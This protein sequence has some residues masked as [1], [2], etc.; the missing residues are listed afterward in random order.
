MLL[1][2]TGPGKAP[3]SQGVVAALVL[4]D[5]NLLVGGGDGS[6][7]VMRTA[8]EPSPVNP[9]VMKKMGLLPGST[10]HLEGGITSLALDYAAAMADA[11]RASA[12]SPSRSRGSSPT[13]GLPFTKPR[14]KPAAPPP[15]FTAY[16]GTGASNMYK[17]TADAEGK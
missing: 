11:L 8:E 10:I 6:L 2:N 17:V 12:G 7:S 3:V 5:G 13:K 1:R 15:L 14:A 4:P 9:K 16:V